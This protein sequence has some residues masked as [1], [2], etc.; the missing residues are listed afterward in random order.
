M[1]T[2]RQGMIA[3]REGI[4]IDQ[5]FAR[6]REYARRHNAALRDVARA[7]VELGLWV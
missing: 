7:V 2:L 5:T 4:S 6:L 3:A 1:F